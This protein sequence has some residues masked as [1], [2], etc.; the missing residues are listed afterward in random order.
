MP[1][2]NIAANTISASSRARDIVLVIALFAVGYL[3]V[4]RRFVST[5][6]DATFGDEGDGEI[7]IAIVEHWHHV[8]SGAV[9]W[10]DPF[11]FYPER[12]TLGYTDSGFLYGLVHSALRAFGFDVFRAYMGVPT[13]LAI[14]GYFGF[15]RLACRHF[16]LV[17]SWAAVG[18][19]LFAFANMI[20]VKLVQ[21]NVYGVML[22]PVVCDFA[23]RAWR[24]ESRWRG[25]ALAATGALLYAL[26]LLTAFPI[27][28]FFAYFMLLIIAISPLVFGVHRMALLAREALTQKRH[29]VLAYIGGF[30]VGIIPFLILYLPVILSGRSRDMAEVLS[31]A[32]EPRDIL[33]VTPGNWLWGDLLQL[34][35]VV[36]RPNRPVW[37][38]ELGFTP[39]VFAIL[40]LTIIALLTTLRGGSGRDMDRDR[41]CVVFGVA[42]L[43]SWLL[44]LDYFGIRPWVAVWALIPGASALRYPFRSQIVANL[45]ASIVVARGL[46]GLWEAAR[47]RQLAMIAVIALTVLLMAEQGNLQ[48]PATI[49]RSA[50]TAFFDA[51]PP[52]PPGCRVFYLVPRAAPEDKPGWEQQAEAMLFAEIR[53]MPTINGY[54]SWLPEGWDLE[55]PA[56]PGYAAAVRDWAERNQLTGLC[57]L[58]PARRIW[59]FGLQAFIQSSVP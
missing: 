53:G 40:V 29:V 41:W 44:E 25:S 9:H 21:V 49:S 33:N 10:T 50:K 24:S 3:L 5:G 51:V 19:F 54:S 38:V 57:G 26:T 45:F 4:F 52:A 31:N 20:A 12:G 18:G 32:P 42:V 27:A 58:D 59:K 48:W 55:E 46:A 17:T 36:G 2:H 43:L 56:K 15:V 28:W 34:L 16:G 6:F 30:V 47:S 1:A 22:M 37:E 39:V 11:F 7:F 8:F 35:N 23:L 14:V 13:T